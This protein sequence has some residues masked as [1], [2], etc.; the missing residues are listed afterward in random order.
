MSKNK[1]QFSNSFGLT[2]LMSVLIPDL[3]Y[4]NTVETELTN[5]KFFGGSLPLIINMCPGILEWFSQKFNQLIKR[6]NS[7]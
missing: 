5:L 2:M 6:G 3:V 7:K 1:K 4:A